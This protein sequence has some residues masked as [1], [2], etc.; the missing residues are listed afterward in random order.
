MRAHPWKLQLRLVA[1]I[2]VTILAPR[3]MLLLAQSGAPQQLDPTETQLSATRL[4]SL[5]APIALYPDPQITQILAASTYPLEIVAA[6]HRA[7]QNGALKGPE[8]PSGASK[9]DWDPSVQA[10]VIFPAALQFMDDNFEWTIALGNAF[11]GQPDAVVAAIQRCREK[12]NAAGTLRPR[13]GLYVNNA[14][15]RHDPY[16]RRGVPYPSASVA[17]RYGATAPAIP[18]FWSAGFRASNGSAGV[19]SRVDTGPQR[20]AITPRGTYTNPR[21]SLFD[22]SARVKVN[23]RRGAASLSAARWAP[24]SKSITQR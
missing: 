19:A 8:I 16:H 4:D 22:C 23:S 7:N 20:V 21:P 2:W 5:V 13:L 24:N 14:P 12:A 1:F 6:R 9:Q 10:L 17:G 15:W 3:Q 18:Y 11:L